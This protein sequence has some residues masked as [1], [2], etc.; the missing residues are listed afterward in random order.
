[1]NLEE[2]MNIFFTITFLNI[3]WVAIWGISYIAIDLIAGKNKVIELA[4]YV[5]IMIF[6]ILILSAKPEFIKHLSIIA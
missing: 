6:V 5:C 1:M 4:I 2:K 3:W